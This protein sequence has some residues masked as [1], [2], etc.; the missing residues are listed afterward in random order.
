MKELL[1]LPTKENIQITITLVTVRNLQEENHSQK[2]TPIWT[3]TSI[4]R[5]NSDQQNVE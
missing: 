1:N 3:L 4:K 2:Q 5:E